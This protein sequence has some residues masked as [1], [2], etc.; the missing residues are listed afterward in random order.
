MRDVLQ[1]KL[2][3]DAINNVS[4]LKLCNPIDRGVRQKATELLHQYSEYTVAH[5]PLRVCDI[6][7][8]PVPCTWFC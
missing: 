8:L 6:V 7:W 1:S 3:N 5:C 2:F 4:W